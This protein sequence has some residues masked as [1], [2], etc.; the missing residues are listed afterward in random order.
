MSL[1]NEKQSL[2]RFTAPTISQ[3]LVSLFLVAPSFA[4]ASS[5]KNF[6]LIPTWFLLA[7]LFS[8]CLTVLGQPKNLFFNKVDILILSLILIDFTLFNFGLLTNGDA[9]VNLLGLYREVGIYIPYFFVRSLYIFKGKKFFPPVLGIVLT[10]YSLAAIIGILQQ[11]GLF[12]FEEL[13]R[14]AY[15]DIIPNIDKYSG[16]SFISRDG[17]GSAIRSYAWFGSPLVFA[18]LMST[19]SIITGSLFLSAIKDKYK[20]IFLSLFSVLTVGMIAGLTRNY[21]LS[22]FVSIIAILIYNYFINSKYVKFQSESR[23]TSVIVG[24]LLTSFVA[25]LVTVSAII[26]SSTLDSYLSKFSST[27]ENTFLNTFSAKDVSTNDHLQDILEFPK[28]LMENPFGSGL[29]SFGVVSSRFGDS[30]NHIEGVWYAQI[31]Q[32]GIFV[33]SLVFLLLFSVAFTI[34]RKAQ[35]NL[36]RNLEDKSFPGLYKFIALSTVGFLVNTFIS[37]FFLPDLYSISNCC[38]LFGSL[39]FSSSVLF[40]LNK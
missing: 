20:I 28:Q 7:L 10:F 31:L 17:K 4:V 11:F 37:G 24:G 26:P 40:S 36:K 32:R 25:I 35:H 21:F 13:A 38:V 30:K 14:A 19:L 3:I 5:A 27:I 33:Q 2:G 15:R 8:F 1:N 29:G 16:T 9:K 12:T 34:I 6:P 39:A 23:N 22:L 18:Q